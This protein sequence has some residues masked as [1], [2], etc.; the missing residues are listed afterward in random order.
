MRCDTQFNFLMYHD[1][2]LTRRFQFNAAGLQPT[3]NQPKVV[4]TFRS[5][6]LYAQIPTALPK[7]ASVWSAQWVSWWNDAQPASREGTTT[8]WK[9]R[10]I[11]S[12]FADWE[13][14]C[15]T[16]DQGISIYLCGLA[17]WASLSMDRKQSNLLAAAVAEV[18]WV[19]ALL[20]DGAEA[21]KV[22]WI[23]QAKDPTTA[24]NVEGVRVRRGTKRALEAQAAGQISKRYVR[25]F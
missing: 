7:S 5:R 4:T 8:M 22:S 21:G 11:P 6:G 18:S 24:S 15:Q 20:V 13:P 10:A 19:L 17:W 14:L 2:R 16:G 9:S 3:K 1:P 23:G 12:D 25:L